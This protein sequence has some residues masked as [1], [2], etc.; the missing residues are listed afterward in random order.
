DPG[1]GAGMSTL[2]MGVL[3]GGLTIYAVMG[4]AD[5]GSGVLALRASVR[6][7]E[8]VVDAMNPIWEANHVWLIFFIT[9]MLTLFPGAFAALGTAVFAPATL[10][11]F[12]IVI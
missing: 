9:G 4:G 6:R 5:F 8:T 7:R 2:L 1:G 10:A 11:L 12:G 3:W